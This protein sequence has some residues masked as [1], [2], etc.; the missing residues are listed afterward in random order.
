[1]LEII[2]ATPTI[3]VLLQWSD[4]EWFVC[5]LDGGPDLTGEV[6]MATVL[7][8]CET[9]YN[10]SH[11]Q[12]MHYNRRLKDFRAFIWSQA[13]HTDLSIKIPLET[14][15]RRK[16]AIHLKECGRGSHQFQSYVQLVTRGCKSM[17][18]S[19]HSKRVKFNQ[20]CI[21]ACGCDAENCC[22]PATQSS[23]HTID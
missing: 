1:M 3:T 8:L 9:C 12:W 6:N 16:M 11:L 17:C 19:A 22:N 10:L 13:L 21:S 14:G 15:A 23:E 7:P 4:I 20:R 18:R 5:L 2:H